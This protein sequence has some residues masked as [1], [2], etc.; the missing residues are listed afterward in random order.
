[1]DIPEAI[2]AD[3]ID[4]M[5]VVPCRRSQRVAGNGRQVCL[6]PGC[7]APLTHPSERSPIGS[8]PDG[9]L[10]SPGA[11]QVV[12]DEGLSVM[13]IGPP[14]RPLVVTWIG[15]PVRA[16]TE[17]GGERTVESCGDKAEHEDRG[18]A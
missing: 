17:Q 15:R 18:Y 2:D 4:I 1:V 7:R 11:P 8:H 9:E 13:K 6:L 12:L 5:E 16:V 10:Q 3:G 14:R